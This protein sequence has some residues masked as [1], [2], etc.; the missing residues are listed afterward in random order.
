MTG[1]HIGVCN[2]VEAADWPILQVGRVGAVGGTP[3]EAVA[4]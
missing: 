2:R 3:V 1:W 4:G